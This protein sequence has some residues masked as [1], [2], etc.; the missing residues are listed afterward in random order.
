[1]RNA[2]RILTTVLVLVL[3]VSVV[4]CSS[5]ANEA[6]SGVEGPSSEDTL[7][8]RMMK[9]LPSDAG[10]LNYIDIASLREEYNISASAVKSYFDNVYEDD[11]LGE[12]INKVNAIATVNDMDI[13]LYSGDFD[14]NRVTANL[15]Q[16]SS[17][18]YTYKGADIWMSEQYR[19]TLSTVIM[20]DVVMTGPDYIIKRCI[21]ITS[22]AELS[23][24]D[25]RDF[26]DVFE[27]LPM[28]VSFSIAASTYSYEPE[29]VLVSADFII[30]EE[31]METETMVLKFT[32]S[33]MAQQYVTSLEERL[34]LSPLEEGVSADITRDGV[35]A[36][37][38]KITEGVDN[39]VPSFE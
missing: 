16:I 17:S 7:V 31:G 19:E 18:S 33:D 27:R 37:L 12:D 9:M 24:Y 4:G 35:F 21:D 36:T 26:K 13:F 2:A 22:N 1:M 15:E 11:I 10:V 20:N 23:L 39:S 25:N 8:V 38:V 32:D 28:G 29:G 14:F 6:S 5:G 30:A 3:I 34:V